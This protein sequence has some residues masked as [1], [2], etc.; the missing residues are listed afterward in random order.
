[1]I[2]YSMQF[3]RSVGKHFAKNK[4]NHE[5]DHLFILSPFNDRPVRHEL[6]Y[7]TKFCLIFLLRGAVGADTVK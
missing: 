3:T 5:I 1:M 6:S 7:M 4:Q 2:Y